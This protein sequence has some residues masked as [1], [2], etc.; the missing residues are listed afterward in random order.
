MQIGEK[1]A[2]P[3][4]PK[5][6]LVRRTWDG[7][8][9]ETK[10][11]QK[12]KSMGRKCSES[13]GTEWFRTCVSELILMLQEFDTATLPVDR[14][15]TGADETLEE[16]FATILAQGATIEMGMVSENAAVRIGI[17]YPEG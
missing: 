8:E 7:R 11:H 17:R 10:V 6:I 5:V 3:E 12:L 15:I 16:D 1:A 9:L 14:V 4:R 13:L 2:F